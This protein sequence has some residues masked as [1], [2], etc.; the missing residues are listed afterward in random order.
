MVEKL[1]GDNDLEAGYFHSVMSLCPTYLNGSLNDVFS[2]L[3]SS[4]QSDG[5]VL[6]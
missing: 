3:G 5:G 6:D 2:D 4:K 1:G